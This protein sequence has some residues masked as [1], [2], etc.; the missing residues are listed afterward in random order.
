MLVKE[1]Q[2]YCP[3]C[4][5]PY[6][7]KTHEQPIEVD[8]NKKLYWEICPACKEVMDECVT[9][10]CLGDAGEIEVTNES[11]EVEKQTVPCCTTIGVS[12]ELLVENGYVEWVDFELGGTMTI[13]WCHVCSKDKKI[14]F[15]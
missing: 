7:V 1:E 10:L 14:K 4:I 12:K 5:K 2:I 8:E 9:L 11:G 15:K 6:K 3:I 13:A